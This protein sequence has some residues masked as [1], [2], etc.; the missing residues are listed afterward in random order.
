MKTHRFTETGFAL[1]KLIIDM[2][3]LETK[4]SDTISIEMTHKAMWETQLA[5]RPHH[6]DELLTC[7]YGYPVTQ[8]E[9]R[10]ALT[11]VKV[12]E[13]DSRD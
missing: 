12:E 6:I 5:I 13:H 9:G 8:I 1:L 7:L 10:D 4:Q 3:L 11:I 2:T